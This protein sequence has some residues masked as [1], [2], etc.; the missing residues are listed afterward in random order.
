MIPN[1]VILGLVP[2]I[3]RSACF[4]ASRWLDGRDK[5]DHDTVGYDL[6]ES[7]HQV[8]V[9]LMSEQTGAAASRPNG[10]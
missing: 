2:G 9:V 3:Q 8:V 5:P 7:E 10:G 6:N 4:E 1:F